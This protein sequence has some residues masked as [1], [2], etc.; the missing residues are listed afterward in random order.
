[1]LRPAW[2]GVDVLARCCPYC[3]AR[4]E[5][6]DGIV[7]LPHATG[8]TWLAMITPDDADQDSSELAG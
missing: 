1:L 4:A 3:G 5:L 7:R 6:A 8:C 2:I